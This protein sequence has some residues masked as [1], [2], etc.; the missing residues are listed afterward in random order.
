MSPD[1][2]VR[3]PGVEDTRLRIFAAAREI[4]AQKGSRG[5]TTREIAERAGVNEATIFR[6]FGTKNQLLQAM[7][8]HCCNA[9]AEE[10]LSFVDRLDGPLDEQLRKLCLVGIERMNERRDL[11]RVAMAEEELNPEAGM[12][13]WR[14][15]TVAQRKIAEYMQRKIDAGELR[16][17]AHDLA[18]L[19]MS[20]TFAY[21]FSAKIWERG[22]IEPERAV[23]L[24]VQLFLHGAK[25]E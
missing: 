13:T 7:L 15:P 6:H 14:S 22:T 5:A 24:F 1:V 17:D 8:D 2:A 18:R 21:V 11:I 3:Q 25:V 20:L 9:D 19:L 10:R 12:L 23:D 4:F 16:G